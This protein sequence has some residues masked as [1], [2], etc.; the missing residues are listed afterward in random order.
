MAKDKEV[1][2]SLL[3]A[4]DDVGMTWLV[5]EVRGFRGQP[6][7]PSVSDA[8][9]AQ[10]RR[11]YNSRGGESPFERIEPI[12]VE[13]FVSP[14]ARDCIEYI[15]ARIQSIESQLEAIPEDAASL[16][17]TCVQLGS[18]F[19]PSEG[20]NGAR[21]FLSQVAESIRQDLLR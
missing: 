16:G 10:S 1:L 13:T 7:E 11:S 9:V 18:E 20:T 14:T 4:L 6:I 12:S 2:N 15:A 5:D 17:V 21:T 3:E 8:L 19:E